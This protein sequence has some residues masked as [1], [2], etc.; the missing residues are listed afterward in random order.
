MLKMASESFIHTL[1]LFLGLVFRDLAMS[2]LSLPYFTLFA[3]LVFAS[4]EFQT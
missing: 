3:K 2:R 4:I 1:L